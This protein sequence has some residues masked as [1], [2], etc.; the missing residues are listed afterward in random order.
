L[1]VAVASLER[2]ARFM[3]DILDV[4][5]RLNIRIDVELDLPSGYGIPLKE[6]FGQGRTLLGKSAAGVALLPRQQV[7]S[8]L[9]REG[10]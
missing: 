10:S 1:L 9:P 5:K 8:E 7:L 2:L 6:I 4:E 3:A